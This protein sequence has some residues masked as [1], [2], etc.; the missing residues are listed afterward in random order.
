MSS[1]C[2]RLPMRKL[3]RSTPPDGDHPSR[4]SVWFPSRSSC[5]GIS[6][7]SN[8]LWVHGYVAHGVYPGVVAGA[9]QYRHSP[10][11]ETFLLQLVLHGEMDLLPL[12]EGERVRW[13]PQEA[14][15]LADEYSVFGQEFVHT[16]VI[17][18]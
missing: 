8:A 1:S 15:L 5:A 16:R 9:F 3:N 2:P 10:V 4:I 12:G 18:A 17:V 11:R 7:G 6:K 13:R 14:I